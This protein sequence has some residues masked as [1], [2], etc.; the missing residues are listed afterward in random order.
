MAKK[1]RPRRPK[2]RGAKQKFPRAAKDNGAPAGRRQ[3]PASRSGEK[4]VRRVKL[5]ETQT[6][7]VRLLNARE[8]IQNKNVLIAKQQI[9]HGNKAQAD[10]QRIK[11]LE[12]EVSDLTNQLMGAWNRAEKAENANL[13]QALE[14]PPGEV[15]YKLDADGLYYY[16]VHEDGSGEPGPG[17]TPVPD[18]AP[19]ELGDDEE[20]GDDEDEPEETPAEKRSRLMAELAGLDADATSGQLQALGSP[21]T[22]KKKDSELLKECVGSKEEVTQGA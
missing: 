22:P 20:E 14:L 11:D 1:N 16:E 9:A 2:P 18:P 7:G 15:E 3:G 10:A 12:A 5:T 21:E 8:L 19:E 4:H 17:K 6:L 13:T